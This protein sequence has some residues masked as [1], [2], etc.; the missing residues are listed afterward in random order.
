MSTFAEL[1]VDDWVQDY[2]F[3]L[4]AKRGYVDNETRAVV[5][6]QWD[7]WKRL[8]IETGLAQNRKAAD[9][10]AWDFAFVEIKGGKGKIFEAFASFIDKKPSTIR[11]MEE[12]RQQVPQGFTCRVC[13]G[14]GVVMREVVRQSDGRIKNAA[15]ACTCDV[16]RLKYGGLQMIDSDIA[17]EIRASSK[18][19]FAQACSWLEE[20]GM[21]KET[22]FAEFWQKLRTSPPVRPVK[23]NTRPEAIDRNLELA[24]YENGDERGWFE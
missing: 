20:R 6:A 1:L 9:E 13:E 17:D 11:E 15:F 23:R 22:T 19:E 2:V 3:A 16:G 12:A 24:I 14:L 5:K 7:N 4:F 10:T 21:S 8:M 18:K